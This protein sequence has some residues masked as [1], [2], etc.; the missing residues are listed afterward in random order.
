VLSAI[1]EQILGHQVNYQT[2]QPTV[3]QG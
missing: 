1:A 2:A 3:K